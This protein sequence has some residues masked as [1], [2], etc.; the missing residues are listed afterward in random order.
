MSGKKIRLGQAFFPLQGLCVLVA[1]SLARKRTDAVNLPSC[2][3]DEC[4]SPQEPC[5]APRRAS[6]VAGVHNPAC[7]QRAH[8]LCVPQFCY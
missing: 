7:T 2:S 6:C 5:L 1:K 8:S 3:V 4:R